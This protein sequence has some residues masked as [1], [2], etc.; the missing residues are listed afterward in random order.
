MSPLMVVFVSFGGESFAAEL[1]FKSLVLLVNFNMVD[2][3]TFEFENL[4]AHFE[5]ALVALDIT[6]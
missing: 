2:Q 5:G 3:T 6:Q 4:T 1:A